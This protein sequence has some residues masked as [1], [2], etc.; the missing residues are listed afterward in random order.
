MN[1]PFPLPDVFRMT[2]KFKRRM[3]KVFKTG[4]SRSLL[5]TMI[6]EFAE[7]RPRETFRPVKLR[8]RDSEFRIKLDENRVVYKLTFEDGLYVGTLIEC[9]K[10]SN[11]YRELKDM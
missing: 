11:D 9:L 6:R 10:R 8:N 2:A 3:A 7:G 5:E 4:R 1:C